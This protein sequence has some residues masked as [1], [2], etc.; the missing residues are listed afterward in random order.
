[1]SE[2]QDRIAQLERDRELLD[3]QIKE[4]L[5]TEHRLAGA[6]MRYERQLRR[7]EL[8]NR[9][10]L[11][12]TGTQSSI[13]LMNL[14]MPMLFSL[15]PFEQAA[16]FT[17]RENDYLCPFCVRALAGR[18]ADSRERLGEIGEQHEISAEAPPK[19]PVLLGDDELGDATPFVRRVVE[20]TRE[21][22]AA[23]APAPS[24]T[25]GASLVMPLVGRG[26][27]ALGAIVLR[28]DA[29]SL[30][31][32]H[33]RLPTEADMPFV[34][35]TAAHVAAALQ[36]VRLFEQVRDIAELKEAYASKVVDAQEQ[37]RIRVA[38]ELHDAIAQQ[39]VAMRMD[40][41]WI[42]ER[43]D[44][45]H[46]AH[47]VSHQLT[48]RLAQTIVSIR[49]IVYDLRPPLLDDLGVA[50]AIKAYATQ[51]T[52]NAEIELDVE[53]V[54]DPEALPQQVATALYRIAQE[55]INN[56]VRHAEA[57]T[58][59]VTVEDSGSAVLLRVRDDGRGISSD[60]LNASTSMGLVGMR[61]RAALLGG[62]LTINSRPGTGTL[63]SAAIPY[64]RDPSK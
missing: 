5:R 35:L 56:A 12:A 24:T 15:F 64:A 62:E 16:A 53:I 41:E 2:K 3:T 44:A 51:I 25:F 4:L 60:K 50:S 23:P 39:L 61:E 59:R 33:E 9:F 29:P 45:D 8:L 46:P 54:D 13:D 55:S 52:S 63:V 27:W 48:T 6:R 38:R 7:I 58:L 43:L 30:I 19:E 1:M 57:T 34:R 22:Y 17:L 10:A 20:V 31:S 36:S 32:S 28:H 21:L 47:D 42:A 40:A 11:A 14:A 26:K 18:E 37:E 49:N